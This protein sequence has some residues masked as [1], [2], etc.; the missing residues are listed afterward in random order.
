MASLA[1]TN[2]LMP[3]ASGS[4]P[5]VAAVNGIT[6]SP[7]TQGKGTFT[8]GRPYENLYAF[9][10]EFK[11]GKVY[12]LREYMDSFYVAKLQGLAS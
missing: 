1:V 12:R 11:D 4:S 6:I 3:R 5:L 7:A 10:I 2:S 8:D 9:A